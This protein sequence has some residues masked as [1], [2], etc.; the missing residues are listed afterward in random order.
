MLYR[1]PC[2]GTP[3]ER[4]LPAFDVLAVTT[5]LSFV[6]QISASSMSTRRNPKI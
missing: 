5:L 3:V 6:S 4:A 1:F 2:R